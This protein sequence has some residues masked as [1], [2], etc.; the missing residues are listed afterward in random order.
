MYLLVLLLNAGNGWIAMIAFIGGLSAATA[1]VIVETVA[2]AIMVSNDLVVPFFLKR[3]SALVTGGS[4]VGALL[5]RTRRIAIFVI[6]VL[7]YLYYRSVGDAQLAAIGLLSFAAI[8]QFARPSSAVCSGGARPP[9][10]VSGILA[11]VVIWGFT[12][13]LPSFIESGFIH[14]TIL[15]TGLFGFGVLRP[16][17]LFGLS[18]LAQLPHGVFWSLSVNVFLFVVVSLL[19]RPAPIEKLQANVFVPSKLTPMAPSFMLWRS[20]VTVEEL[21]ATIARYLGEERTHRSFESFATTR[22]L[23]LEPKR[24]ADVHLLRYAEHLWLP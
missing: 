7:A 24:E 15:D 21:L 20:R 10:A 2:L 13:L 22:G 19:T 5:L 16:Q 11:G 14:R 1:M 23:S 18:G 6:L 12:L 17:A 4:D 3:R 9:G 8:A